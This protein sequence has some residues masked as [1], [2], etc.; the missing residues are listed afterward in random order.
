MVL[1]AH[2]HYCVRLLAIDIFD[3]N[4]FRHG[5]NYLVA[6]RCGKGPCLEVIL[7]LSDRQWN[8]IEPILPSGPGK[9]GRNGNDNRMSLEGMIWICRTG[10]PW[11]DLP[12]VFGKWDTVYRRFRRWVAAGVFDS[13]L[14]EIGD[15]LRM[16]SAIRDAK[17]T[18]R[19]DPGSPSP[20]P[21][22]P[23]PA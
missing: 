14:D 11:R 9:P 7:T 17:P 23:P 10:A 21:L 13:I 6:M 20:M 2:T 3:E 12:E 18:A 16:Q 22:Q 4:H 1:N 19:F 8:L 5:Y 15:E